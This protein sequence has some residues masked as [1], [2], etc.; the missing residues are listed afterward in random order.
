MDSYHV[1]GLMSGT[2]LDGVDLAYCNFHYGKKW[3]F[4][5]L[6][7]DFFAYSDNW[8]TKL[9]QAYNSKPEDL[10][11]LNE[12]Y[13]S[14][15][16]Q[17][18][19]DFIKEHKLKV[20]FI[21]SHGH[22]IFHRPDKGYTL[23]IGDGNA[24]AKECQFPVVYDFRSLDVSLN[25][26]GAPLVPIG[27][28]LLFKKFDYCLNLGGFANIST[29]FNE[30]RIAYDICSVNLVLNYLC[31]KLGHTFD[32]DGK[33]GK[34]GQLDHNLLNN[35]NSLAFYLEAHPKS[36]GREWVESNIFPL[37][38]K[39]EISIEDQLRTYYEH[40]VIQIKKAIKKENAS[41]LITG[42]GTHNSFLIELFKAHKL[43]IVIP[44][45]DL[46]DFKEALIFAFLGVLRWRN[47]VNCLS[48]V[49]GASRNS[50][51]GKIVY[52]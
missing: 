5:I 43:N 16:G 35:L 40:I 47:E 36:L 28:K 2:S 50:S 26:Q 15:L 14:Y 25:G 20:D 33:L 42:G 8:K 11:N 10:E 46:I 52:P 24:I 32:K 39:S 37:F 18:V 7:K 3:S 30:Q 51:G 29:Q 49:T 17:L 45:K 9:Q 22:T 6:K 23:Q 12:E 27:D 38:K 41:I 21:A 34:S 31:N 19:F 13:G 1:I 48:S 4:E 44:E